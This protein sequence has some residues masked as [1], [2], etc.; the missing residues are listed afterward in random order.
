MRK[1]TADEKAYRRALAQTFL[2][3]LN[4][5]DHPLFYGRWEY[6]FGPVKHNQPGSPNEITITFHATEIK[7]SGF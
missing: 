1:L 6:D 4:R 3:L 7:P 2:T 5:S